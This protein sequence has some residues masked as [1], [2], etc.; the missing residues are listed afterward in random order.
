METD[1][2]T[3]TF[4]A[5]EPATFECRIDGNLFTPCTLEQSYTG[6]DVGQHTFEVRATDV[7]GNT[8]PTPA[9]RTWTVDVPPQTTIDS[10]PDGITTPEDSATF[11]FSANA[12]RTPPSSAV[13]TARPDDGLHH[14]PPPTPDLADGTHTI[15]VA[16][17]VNGQT[18]ATPARRT[19]TVDSSAPPVVTAGDD[20]TVREAFPTTKLRGADGAEGRHPR[21]PSTCT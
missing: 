18:D 7:S 13:S 15:D 8:D 6:L 19:W 20:A 16:A 1:A 17:S 12:A 3:F 9:S 10:G 21:R 2:A 5:D 4:S 14:S 11:Q